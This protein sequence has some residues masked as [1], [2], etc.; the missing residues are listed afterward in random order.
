[1]RRARPLSLG[2]Q[3]STDD[4]RSV[5][6]AGLYIAEDLAPALHEHRRRHVRAPT[7]QKVERCDASSAGLA[8][9]GT[10]DV[11]IIER[12]ELVRSML[13]E[14]LE[15]EGI[16]AA[17]AS[18]DE[19]LQLLPHEVPRVVITGIN[20]G[21]NEDM[22]G[23]EVVAALRRKWPRICAVYLSALWP[24]RLSRAGLAANE[25]FLPKPVRLAQVVRTVRELLDS[26]LCSESKA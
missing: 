19:A 9:L 3:L 5:T 21:H 4:L 26:G 12:D 23:L 14:T 18:D 6:P 13:T 22:T 11:L 24:L 16:S 7:S 1:M 2:G 15:A 25:R 8:G 10:M 20:R 17:A